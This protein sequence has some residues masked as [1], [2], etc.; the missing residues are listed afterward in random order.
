MASPLNH[1]SPDTIVTV[2]S[3]FERLPPEIRHKVYTYLN[4][5]VGTHLWFPEGF[6]WSIESM[7]QVENGLLETNKAIRDELLHLF[8]DHIEVRF[9]CPLFLERVFQPQPQWL[10][11][12]SFRF[13][14]STFTCIT[15]IE[16][17]DTYESDMDRH[18]ATVSFVA[19]HCPGLLRLTYTTNRE[20]LR[21]CSTRDMQDFILACRDL[22]VSCRKLQELR[23]LRSKLRLDLY[24]VTPSMEYFVIESLRAGEWDR[25]SEWAWKVLN[26]VLLGEDILA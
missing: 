26:K 5:P 22:T 8:F 20:A 15:C 17:N 13:M 24:E 9:D 4:F 19:G 16:L 12:L 10:Y 3:P 23:F 14:P 21:S 11:R 1:S 6:E 7:V 2:L 18:I 25:L